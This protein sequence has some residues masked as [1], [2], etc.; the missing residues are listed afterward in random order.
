MNVPADQE[1]GVGV[2]S[3]RGGRGIGY[4]RMGPNP[5]E[6]FLNTEM[7]L[8]DQLAIDRTV[9]ANERTL[10]AYIRTVLALVLAGATVIRIFED[11]S[12]NTLGWTL[13]AVG[14][15]VGGIGFWRTLRISRRVKSAMNEPPQPDGES[16]AD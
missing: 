15:F 3:K 11:P 10:L 14:V 2:Q 8:R 1:K 7:I 12:L 9:L 4:R 13:I 5:Y 6:R 16:R